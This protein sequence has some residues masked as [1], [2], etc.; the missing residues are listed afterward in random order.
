MIT[1]VREQ[2]YEARNVT[3]ILHTQFCLHMNLYLR[4]LNLI[5]L[6]ANVYNLVHLLIQVS[7]LIV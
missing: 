4:G 5:Q 7:N 3:A 6:N 2:I 1:R